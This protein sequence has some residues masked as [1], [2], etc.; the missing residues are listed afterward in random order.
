MSE[1]GCVSRCMTKVSCSSS[2]GSGHL[3]CAVFV[4]EPVLCRALGVCEDLVSGES[5]V[6]MGRGWDQFT[7]VCL[8]ASCW[9]PS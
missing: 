6:E 9:S 5:G 3:R 4:A 2:L 7:H 8:K 1:D